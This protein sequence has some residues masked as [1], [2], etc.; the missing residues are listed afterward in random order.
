MVQTDHV[1]QRSRQNAP[2]LP[3]LAMSGAMEL[4]MFTVQLH[5][6]AIDRSGV[7]ALT[8]GK[9]PDGIENSSLTWVPVR[10]YEI[11]EG[12]LHPPSFAATDVRIVLSAL[13]ARS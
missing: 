8:L 9:L 11:H 7:G 6:G 1:V 2:L 12:G 4:P 3:R 10:R 5:R 13:K